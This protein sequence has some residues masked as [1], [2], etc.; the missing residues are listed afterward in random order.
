MQKRLAASF[1][2][3]V[4]LLRRARPLA[5]FAPRALQAPAAAE[6]ERA[7]G[8]F[9]SASL[10]Q[11][12]CDFRPGGFDDAPERRAGYAH[13]LCRL[14]LG[15]AFEVGEPQRFKFIE[16]EHDAFLPPE[17]AVPLRRVK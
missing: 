16:R 4:M 1:T 17:A 3:D 5:P 8:Y 7:A 15:A 12:P 9:E 10:H 13:P 2:F 11:R 14:L 6:H